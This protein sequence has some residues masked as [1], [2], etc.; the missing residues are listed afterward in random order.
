VQSVDLKH[1][2]NTS[3]TA[4]NVAGTSRRTEDLPLQVDIA[5]AYVSEGGDIGRLIQAGKIRLRIV[6][7]WANVC[8]GCP[9]LITQTPFYY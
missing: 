1:W 7:Q 9:E 6:H 5:W 4:L 2:S 8:H 3:K